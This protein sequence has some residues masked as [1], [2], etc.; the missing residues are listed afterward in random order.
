[1][2]I[3]KGDRGEDQ[4]QHIYGSVAQ[5]GNPMSGEGFQSKRI[6]DGTYIIEFD[7]QFKGNPA[8]VCTIA[9]PEWVTFN[10]SVAIVDVSEKHFICVTSSPVRPID[11]SFTFIAFGDV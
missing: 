3:I 1:M 5:D 4:H 6:K 7:Q 11:S 9:G 8:P 2:A 10:L